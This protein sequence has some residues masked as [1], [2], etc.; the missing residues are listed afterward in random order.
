MDSLSERRNENNHHRAMDRVDV[1]AP[2][3]AEH[4]AASDSLLHD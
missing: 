4:C 3:N 2:E 1:A